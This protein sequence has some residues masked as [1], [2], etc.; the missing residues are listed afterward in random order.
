MNKQRR[1]EL[2]EVVAILD[3]ATSRLQEIRDDE[4]ESFDNLPDGLQ[5]S[6]T[7]E[8]MLKA[9]E[10][11]NWFESS[12]DKFR[13]GIEDFATPKHKSKPKPK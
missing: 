8:S 12:I 6:K 13:N 7:G 11:L 3:D 4:Q 2:L 5:C 10:E 1:E 9:I